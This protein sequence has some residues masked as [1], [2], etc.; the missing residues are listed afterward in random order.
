MADYP[1]FPHFVFPMARNPETGSVAVVE[2]D[3][4]Q[5]IRCQELAVIVT[6]LGFRE[7]RPEFGWPWPE[8]L[9]IPSAAIE[10]PGRNLSGLAGAIAE[11]VPDSF[12][13]LQEWS[14]MFDASTRH[15][16][17]T[18]RMQGVLPE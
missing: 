10:M 12:S 5:H 6:P 18:E 8:F 13:T 15:I 11:F 9:S 1:D 14:D 16:R 4:P 2:Q 17:L 7:D 3:S